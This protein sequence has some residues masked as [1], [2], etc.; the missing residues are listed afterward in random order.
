MFLAACIQMSSD[1]DVQSNLDRA[2][3]YI[4][5]AAARG[6][7]LVVTPENTAL[8]GPQFHKVECA[9]TLDGPTATRLSALAK[10]LKIHLLIGSLAE[11]RVKESGELDTKRCYNTSVLY[12]PKGE[13]IARYRKIHLF[14]VDVPGGLTIKESDSI[15]PGDELVR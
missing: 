5:R 9:E 10:E 6:A 4:R 15:C 14:D 11:R 13:M 3:E 7:A 2:E 8:L 12:G 1:T